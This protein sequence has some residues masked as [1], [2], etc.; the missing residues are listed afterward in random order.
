MREESA[1]PDRSVAELAGRQHG[2]VADW[3]LIAIGMSTSSISRRVA[4]G[5]LHRIHRGVYAVGHRALS[6]QGRLMAAVLACGRDPG[7]R[8]GAAGPDDRGNTVLGQWGAA[9]SHRGAA[10]L[11]GLLPLSQGPVDVSV[12]GYGGRARRWGIRVHRS[13]SLLPAV[14]TLRQ[15]IAVTTPGRTI[16]DLRHAASSNGRQGLVSPKELRRA[17]RQANVLGLSIGAEAGRDRT[18]SDLERAFLRL[19]RRHRL[20]APEVNVRV[21]QHLVDFLWRDRRLVVET[22]GYRYHRGRAAFDDDRSRD[23]E[24]RGGGYEVIRI[25]ERQVEEQPQQIAEVLATALGGEAAPRPDL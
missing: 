17:I 21:G 23:L 13:Q 9:L 11:W 2:V 22:D 10:N 12:P 16:S 1:R 5:R 6:T 3:Q 8:E 20:P 24:L 7:E 4:A 15:G 19:C 18:R 14:V 25:S